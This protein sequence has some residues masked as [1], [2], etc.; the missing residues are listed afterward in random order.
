[1]HVIMIR[2]A[3]TTVWVGIALWLLS[4]AARGVRHVIFGGPVGERSLLDLYPLGL[5]VIV[6]ILSVAFFNR[7]PWG[8]WGLMLLTLYAG[9]VIGSSWRQTSLILVNGNDEGRGVL[10]L[11]YGGFLGAAAFMVAA[12]LYDWRKE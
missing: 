1:M 11:F 9:A 5:S 4:V 6:L 10:A 12:L 7:R 3:I 2:I 8:R